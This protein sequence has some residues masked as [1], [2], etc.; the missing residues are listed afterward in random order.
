MQ[1][2]HHEL[3]KHHSDSLLITCNACIPF[4]CSNLVLSKNLFQD[5]TAKT[6]TWTSKGD[7]IKN[8]CT[9]SCS[10]TKIPW[11]GMFNHSL[12]HS[13][14]DQYL[15]ERNK[16]AEILLSHLYQET[17]LTECLISLLK[18]KVDVVQKAK[19][20]VEFRPHPRSQPRMFLIPT[21]IP[22]SKCGSEKIINSS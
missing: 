7:I 17:S 21:R 13:I 9:K 22:D 8:L 12:S 2:N 4:S 6:L 20:K 16:Q 15:K 1:Q 19:T 14:S 5:S 18:W 10:L 11:S 3:E